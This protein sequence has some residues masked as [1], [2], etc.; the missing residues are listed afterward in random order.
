MKKLVFVLASFAASFASALTTNP[1]SVTCKVIV[2]TDAGARPVAST[3][4]NCADN[5]FKVLGSGSGVVAFAC[6]NV[7]AK[8]D[9]SIR[10][11]VMDQTLTAGRTLPATEASEFTSYYAT[12]DDVFAINCRN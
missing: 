2:L 3:T 8:I 5:D 10:L 12:L 9:L 11:P 7:G 1:T 6:E 4:L